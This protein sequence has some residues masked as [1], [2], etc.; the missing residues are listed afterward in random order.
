[1]AKK[2][3][4]KRRLTSD[5]FLKK[6]DKIFKGKKRIIQ[7]TDNIG[8]FAYSITSLSTYGYTIDDVTLD[9]KNEGDFNNV[10]TEY[11]KKFDSLGIKICRLKAHSNFTLKKNLKATVYSDKK[12]SD[13][14]KNIEGKI[15]S[16]SKINT[17]RLENKKIS[18]I[19]LNKHGKKRRGTFTIKVIDDVKPIIWLSSIYYVKK[20][21]SDTIESSIM[22]A[23][24]YDKNLS[25]K[26]VG[27]Y[28]LNTI[29]SYK[30]TYVA[31][32][33]IS[34]N[35]IVKKY[36]TKNNEIGIDVSRHQEIIDFKRVKESNASFVIIRLG[37]QEGVNGKYKVDPYFYKNIKNA[38]K[39]NLKVGVYFYSYANSTIEAKKQA[40]WVINKIKK[41]KITM[42]VAF[43]WECYSTFNDMSLSLFG[44]NDV[45]NTFLDE[46]K[47]RGYKVML[48]ASKNY[49]ESIWTYEKHPIWLAHYTSYTN[50]T[51]KYVMWQLTDKG[52]IDGIDKLTDI[53]IYYK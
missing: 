36:K 24:N 37:Y 10:Q 17:N 13:Y 52:K 41:Y 49:L 28:D 26:I 51:G 53:D 23:D 32:D 35:D 44:L 31:T 47:K 39:N 6:Y 38:I 1:M 30:L 33:S 16:D 50:Y 45:S 8:L 3:H 20:G 9:L 27:T 25:R 15:V 22:A 11:E 48:Y 21:S 18:F 2:R 14:I 43:D 5:T 42:P 12:I 46:V 29:G 40:K 7:K 34:F 19:Y 4:A